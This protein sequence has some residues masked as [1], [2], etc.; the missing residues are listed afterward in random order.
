MFAAVISPKAPSSQAAEA[1]PQ[2]R[3]QLIERHLPLVSYTLRRMS[4]FLNSGIMEHEDAFSYGVKGL[5][6]AVD[7]YDSSR[8]TTFATY[9]VVRIRGAVIDAARSMDFLPRT[10]RQRIRALEQTTW[11]LTT[12]LG[13][14]PTVKEISLKTGLPIE[15]VKYI[16][17][18]RGANVQSLE[19]TLSSHDDEYEW[20]LED[21]DETINPA[22]VADRKAVSRVLGTAMNAME[23]RDRE[24][25]DM[26]YNR[27]LPFGVIGD[28]L[29]ISESRVSQIHHRIIARLRSHLESKGAA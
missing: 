4:E 9:A 19:Q 11:E 13:R 27:D 12:M 8:G 26:H 22:A 5:I 23:K 20:Q 7:N 29:S 10:Q 21:P 28:Y 24:I 17:S 2:T 25:L 14:W 6:N 1:T 18:Q 16:Q 3:E 15:D